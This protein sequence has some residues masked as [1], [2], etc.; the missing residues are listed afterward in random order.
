MNNV[1]FEG[2]YVNTLVFHLYL[3]AAD[4]SDFKGDPAAVE[5][6]AIVKWSINWLPLET[7]KFFLK[8]GFF[9]PVLGDASFSAADL[10]LD[11]Q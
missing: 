7:P 4:R 6:L 1:T 9:S 5:A 3:K 11:T 2:M 8:D 10:F